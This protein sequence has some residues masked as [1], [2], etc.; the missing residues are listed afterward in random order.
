MP[1]VSTRLSKSQTSD[2]IAICRSGATR[3]NHLANIV[4]QSKPTVKRSEFRRIIAE[5]LNHEETTVS[6]MRALSGLATAIRKFN[7]PPSDLFEMVQSSLGELTEQD[8]LSWH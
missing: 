3:L 8:M 4:E 6:A 5:T 1:S 2:L 7:I